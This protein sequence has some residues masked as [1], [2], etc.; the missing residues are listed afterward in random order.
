MLIVDAHE[1]I[2]WNV[3]TFGRDYTHSAEQLR[4]GEKNTPIPSQNGNSMLGREDWLSARVA[5]IFATLFSS[6]VRKKLGDWDTQA[7][8][9]QEDAYVLANRQIDV[10]DELVSNH[11]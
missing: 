11:P 7:Y 6:P 2:A 4:Y 5:V 10:Y 3:R 8:S 9:N 1:D